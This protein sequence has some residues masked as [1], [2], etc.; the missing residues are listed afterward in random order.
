MTYPTVAVHPSVSKIAL[1]ESLL[2]QCFLERPWKSLVVENLHHKLCKETRDHHKKTSTSSGKVNLCVCSTSLTGGNDV[3]CPIWRGRPGCRTKD[4]NGG[5]SVTHTRFARSV[6]RMR[7]LPDAETTNFIVETWAK[8]LCQS[9][10]EARPKKLTEQLLRIIH[11]LQVTVFCLCS[12]NSFASCTLMW[13]YHGHLEWY[14]FWEE[15]KPRK[16]NDK[17]LTLVSC[18]QHS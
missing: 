9:V 18:L 5:S 10:C 15:W 2:G 16:K 12:P 6:E 14:V 4:M 17:M 11:R 7:L 3:S 1:L 13:Q 8:R